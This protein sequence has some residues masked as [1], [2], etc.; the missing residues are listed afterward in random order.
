MAPLGR[1]NGHLGRRIL[2]AAVPS[3]FEVPLGGRSPP[4]R[5]QQEGGYAMPENI[6]YSPA[7]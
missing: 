5:E 4:I 7:R 3:V 2:R 6:V 1:P